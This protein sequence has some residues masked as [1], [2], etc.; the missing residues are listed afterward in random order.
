MINKKALIITNPCSGK[1]KT[2]NIYKDIDSL[3]VGNN[4]TPTV[5]TTTGK[6]HATEIALEHA[7]DYDLVVCRG[8]DGTFSEMLNG[9]M[10][11]KKMPLIGYIPSGTTNELAVAFG[12]STDAK[13]AA[14]AM[15]YSNSLPND[16][17]LFNGSKYFTYV[18]SFGAFSRCSYAASQKLKNKIGRFAYFYESAKEFKD[19]RPIPM[20]VECDGFV[21]EGEYVI[22]SVSN[23]HSIG[24]IIKLDENE[25]CLN[26]GMF[27]VFLGKNPG[28]V[29]G[30]KDMLMSI[31]RKKFDE[32]YIRIIKTGQAKFTLLQ[33]EAIPWS[34]DG[35]FGGNN[36]TVEIDV[37]QNAYNIISP[38]A[39]KEAMIFA[40]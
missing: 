21:E 8:G 38:K 10:K 11:L 12:I 15:F 5:I 20:R 14:E 22:G 19:I 33:D 32:R 31:A 34:I 16:I 29:S 24:K 6:G 26:D 28:S 25:V 9:L 40:G 23:S 2:R 18:A 30:W 27:E 1:N 37:L 17:G 3:F 4:Y 35:E 7:S 39:E 36:K 13:T